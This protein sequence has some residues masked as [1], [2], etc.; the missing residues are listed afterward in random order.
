[1]KKTETLEEELNENLIVAH[2]RISEC[3]NFGKQDCKYVETGIVE[4]C[5]YCKN[6]GSY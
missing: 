4:S 5:L 6:Y 3:L 2:E 1:M